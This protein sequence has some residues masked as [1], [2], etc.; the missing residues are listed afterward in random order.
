MVDSLTHETIDGI[1]IFKL[2]RLARDVRIQENLIH[3]IQTRK[4]KRIISVQ[5]SD[6]DSKDPTR[7]LVRQI[8]GSFSQY[9]KSQIAMRLSLGRLNKAR[10]GG[11]AGGSRPTGYRVEN[12][13]LF[14]NEM[15][16]ST[17]K[18][19]FRMKAN[20]KG[21]REIARELNRGNYPTTR[22]GAWYAATV[23]YILNNSIYR[24]ASDYVGVRALRPE[25]SIVNKQSV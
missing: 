1:L 24:G 19:I 20:H 5:E 2:D 4:G 11:Y 17:V 16:A 23:R 3:D 12:K 10:K 21:L 6:L 22:G 15:E 13:D 9:E 8:L 7:V 18:A 14:I 25:L